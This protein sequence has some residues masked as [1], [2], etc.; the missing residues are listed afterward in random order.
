MPVIINGTNGVNIASTTGVINLLGSTSG[1]ITLQANATAG[2]NTL[3]LPASTG[4]FVISGQN[5]AITA[6][7][8]ANSTS[9]TSI[10]FNGIPSWVKRITVIFSGTSTSGSSAVIVRL[11]TAA[12]FESTGYLGSGV[13]TGPSTGSGN[14]TVGLLACG[15]ST[16]ASVSTHGTMVIN[17]LTSNSWTSFYVAGQSDSSYAVFA[18]GSKT[19]SGTLTR[20]RVTTAN[21][22]DTFDAGSINIL[23]E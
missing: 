23:Y 1:A 16:D 21:G 12:S 2:T 4:T 9:G 6:G 7:T 15:G 14:S 5:S 17:N 3:T 8:A 10:D 19:L 13:F 20:I 18:G 11:G 22:T